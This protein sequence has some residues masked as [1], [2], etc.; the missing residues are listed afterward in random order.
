MHA[1]LEVPFATTRSPNGMVC[2][3]DHLAS[4]AGIAMMRSGGNAVDAAIATSAVL[5]VTS[6]HMCG[7]GGDLWA[8][9]HSPGDVAPRA[10]N[11]SG[12]AGSGADPERARSEGLSEL[13]LLGDIRIT[14]VPGCVD[15]WVALHERYGSLPLSTLLE[16]A[17][18]YAEDGFPANPQLLNSLPRVADNDWAGD[19]LRQGGLVPGDLI[20]RPGVARTLEAVGAEGRDAF[21]LGEFGAGLLELGGGEYVRSDLERSQADWVDPIM[22]KAWGHDVWTVPPN[23]QG[24]LSLASA[25]IAEGLDLPTDA[26]DPLWA[27]LLAEASKQ[28]GYDRPDVLHEHAD[29]EF[30]VSK[31]R[32]ASRQALIDNDSVTPVGHPGQSGD[33]M[34][35]CAVDRNRV[36]VSLIQSNAGGWGSGLAELKTRIF[37]HNR[38]LGFNLIPGHPAEYGPGRRPPHTL[39]PALVTSEG[40]LRT[41]LGTMGGDSQ[42]QVVLQLLARLLHTGSSPG[43]AIAAPRFRLYGENASGFHT[44]AEPGSLVVQVE[45]HAPDGWDEGLVTRGHKIHRLDRHDSAFGHAHMIDVGPEGLAGAADPRALVG[46]AVGM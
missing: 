4:S 3:I 35:M 9:I 29:G 18:G 22:V 46:A 2:S 21:Y 43:Q 30:L 5:A 8:L 38:G 20:R 14:P 6:Q 28:A 16:P 17:V 24:Y 15:G 1:R 34:Y 19:Y 37:L 26:E 40:R 10:L 41:V 27:H 36:G 25:W 23:S 32:L 44:W 7:M 42:P 12:R 31:D 11:S 13:P 45:G 39:A 33:T